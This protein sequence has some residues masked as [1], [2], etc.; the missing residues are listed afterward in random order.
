MWRLVACWCCLFVLRYNPIMAVDYRDMRAVVIEK[1]TLQALGGDMELTSAEKTC[2]ER[3][4]RL[5]REELYG[6]VQPWSKNFMHV[7]NYIKNSP[8]FKIIRRIPKGSSLHSHLFA[9]AS[10]KYVLNTVL[11]KENIYVCNIDGRIKLK[12]LRSNSTEPDC[13]LLSDKRRSVNFDDWIKCHLL[14]SDTDEDPWISFRRIFSFTYDLYSYVNVLEEYVYRVMEEHYLDNVM[15]LEV[16]TPFLAMYDLNGTNYTNLDFVDT[17]WK[18]T[19]R[20]KKN[21]RDFIGMK[22]IYALYRGIDVETVKE[23][24]NELKDINRKHP[25]FV[26]AVDFVGFEEE[27]TLL[28][29][30]EELRSVVGDVRFYFHAGETK[31]QG[32]AVDLNILDAILFDSKR[33]AHAYALPKHPE[34]MKLIKEKNIAIEVCPIS[35]QVLGLVADLRNHPASYL[36]AQ[37]YP[38]VICND[39][40]GHWNAKGLSYDWYLAFMA[41][42]SETS[43]LRLL[44]KFAINSLEYSTLNGE[45][46]RTA[47][48]IWE[49]KWK[50]FIE[51]WI[52]ND[53]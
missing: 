37:G 6:N 39:D 26:A 48:K 30:A 28:R 40:P 45:E 43:G 16:R 47:F 10:H 46:K 32:A 42:S 25:D 5:K 20:F 35:N 49:A 3:L 1:E 13:E 31:R 33:I 2:D 12:F 29:Y 4:L 52:I 18:T 8:I 27:G 24:L 23:N 17:L 15:Y 22:L 36:I 7:R 34:F 50:Q 41:M 38:V 9:S 21:H 44:K 53:I 19:E 11:R 14:V 51:N